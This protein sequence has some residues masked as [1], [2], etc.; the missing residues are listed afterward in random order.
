[1]SN[2]HTVKYINVTQ[3]SHSYLVL[4]LEIDSGV[5]IKTKL[6]DIRADFTIPIANSHLSV[7]LFH[8]HRRTEFTFL[9]SYVIRGLVPSAVMF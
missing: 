6:N 2:E 9:N 4:H 1:M 5:I 8:Q 3:V 7:A